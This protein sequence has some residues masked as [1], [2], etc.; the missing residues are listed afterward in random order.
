MATPKKA[1][2][3]PKAKKAAT[4]RQPTPAINQVSTTKAM[5]AEEAKWRAQDDVRILREAEKIKLDQQRL[6]MAQ[7]AA[8]EEMQALKRV[9]N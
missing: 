5:Q 6:K 4:P 2:P 9:A 7:K 8:K 3:K 1:T